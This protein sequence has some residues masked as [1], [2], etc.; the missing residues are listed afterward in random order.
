MLLVHPTENQW[1]EIKAACEITY[2]LLHKTVLIP[3]SAQEE[4]APEIVFLDKPPALRLD[5]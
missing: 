3:V 5:V 4:Q 1:W 2:H